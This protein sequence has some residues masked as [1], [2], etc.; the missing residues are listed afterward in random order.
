MRIILFLL[1]LAL[2][3]SA[4]QANPYDSRRTYTASA[5]DKNRFAACQTAM[6]NA[7]TILTQ[8]GYL[9]PT[10][11]GC[12]CTKM[13]LPKWSSRSTRRDYTYT[14]QVTGSARKNPYGDKPAYPSYPY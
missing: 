13:E 6:N 12:Q 5:T 10:V 2:A 7:R 9:T 11:G 1:M 8:P 4:A 14:C 3:A